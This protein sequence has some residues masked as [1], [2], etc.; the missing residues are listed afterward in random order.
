VN[1]ELRKTFDL[2][3]NIRPCVAFPGVDTPFHGT[4][5]VVIRENLQG[6][7]TGQ[8]MYTDPQRSSAVVMAANSRVVMERICRYGC[9]WARKHSRKKITCVHKANILKIF[10][11][12]FLDSFRAVSKEFPDLVFE[13]KIV[14][15][16]CMELVRKPH[17]FDVI[18]TTNMFGDILS[19]LTAGLIGGL[20]LAP[21]GN[22]GPDAA[23]FEAIHGSAPD[24]AGKN[25]ANP[26]S[27]ILAGAMMLKYIGETEKG[28]KIESAV[29]ALLTEGKELTPDLKKGSSITTTDLTKALIR[30]L[31]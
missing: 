31:G 18:I 12:I 3:A 17:T 27:I 9:E 7:Y 6:L 19:D 13:E 21:G 26:I 1:V 10:S 30:H 4:D 24:I 16:V 14:D 5:I 29:R 2:F 28:L 23:M 22:Y 25:I 11:G 15:A 20:G 8:E